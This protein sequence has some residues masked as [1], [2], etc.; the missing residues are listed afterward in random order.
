MITTPPRPDFHGPPSP[1]IRLSPP[2]AHLQRSPSPPGPF[3]SPP[4][5]CPPGSPEIIPFPLLPLEESPV[6]VAKMRCMGLI[7][8]E[9]NGQIEARLQG[10]TAKLEASEAADQHKAL[11]V[12]QLNEDRDILVA[13]LRSLERQNKQLRQQMAQPVKMCNG[14]VLAR[15]AD[16]WAR[17]QGRD[18]IRGLLAPVSYT[19]LTL[20]TKRIV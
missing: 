4:W 3:A 16:C 10:L 1:G 7:K 15:L 18:C 20:P 17:G 2:H 19:H 5:P 14:V 9:L 13:Q 8:A 11:H 6:A 12:V